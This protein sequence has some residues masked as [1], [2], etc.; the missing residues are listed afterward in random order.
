MKTKKLILGTALWGWAISK[1]EAF[2]IL[3]R[4]VE[5]GNS[6][7]DCATNYPINKNKED[8]GLALEWLSQWCS[9]N[10]NSIRIL[11]KIGSVDNLGSSL[12]DLSKKCIFSEYDD[13]LLN[14]G[15]S[16]TCIS[17]HW[18]NRKNSD[19][20]KET[21]FALN[22][23][24]SR[25]IDIGLSGIENPKDYYESM[26]ELA[27]CWIIQCKENLLTNNA[28]LKY[29]KFFPKARYCAYGINIGGLK[30]AR[31]DSVSAKIR[32]IEHPNRL[33]KVFYDALNNN[34]ILSD[35]GFNTI[36]DINMSFIYTNPAYDGIIIGPRNLGQLN[37]TL[38]TFHLLNSLSLDDR[39]DLIDFLRGLQEQIKRLD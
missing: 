29:Q 36:N 25:D 4:F 7:V 24:R 33:R 12:L 14:F 30:V 39:V 1:A 26:P 19:L 2:S 38:K 18:D 17:V 15:N 3:D 13:L 28:R 5:A 16:L 22:E 9:M 20:I 37:S 11:V 6:W 35:I 8:Y 31:D 34:N 21:V 10:K 27:D 32:G 23:L